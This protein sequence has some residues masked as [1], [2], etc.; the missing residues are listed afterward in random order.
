MGDPIPPKPGEPP[1]SQLPGYSAR[2]VTSN[3]GGSQVGTKK[4]R[5][6][7]QILADEEERRNILEIKLTKKI[8]GA[9]ENQAR[10]ESLSL[11]KIG[12]LLF[13]VIKI[14]AEECM[15]VALVTNRYDT[16]EVMLKP[17]VDPTPYLTTQPIIWRDQ[18]V[19]VRRRR[20]SSKTAQV[21][22]KNVPLCVP[23]E[24]IINLLIMR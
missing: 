5:T 20:Q 17:G 22:F 9:E 18:Q 24:E 14:K 23:D 8:V 10:P 12:E 13:D 1:P 21:T 3:E 7:A 11:E 15:R 16:K 6:F 4:L 19:T 2:A